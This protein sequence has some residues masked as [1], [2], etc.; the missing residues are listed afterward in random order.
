MT[1]T[2]QFM[3][4]HGDCPNGCLLDE[5]TMDTIGGGFPDDWYTTTNDMDVYQSDC[6]N[7]AMGGGWHTIIRIR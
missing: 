4:Y 6:D 5:I 7:S 3:I 2:K 1:D